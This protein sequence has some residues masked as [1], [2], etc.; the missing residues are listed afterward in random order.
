MLF[1]VSEGTVANHL[2]G[3]A[4]AACASAVHVACVRPR[5]AAGQWF[6]MQHA[7]ATPVAR[8]LDPLA[9]FAA[10]LLPVCPPQFLHHPTGLGMAGSSIAGMGTLGGLWDAHAAP[11]PERGCHLPP[12]LVLH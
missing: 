7:R 8:P 2:V 12:M 5:P 11:V 10:S 4:A 6:C 1:R 9:A 3:C